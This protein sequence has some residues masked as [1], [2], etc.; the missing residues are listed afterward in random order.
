MNIDSER[1]N[2]V[3]TG[4]KEELSKLRTARPSTTLIEDL[5]VEC[6]GKKMPLKSM[7]LIS[8]K[9]REIIV[10]PWDQSYIEAIEKAIYGSELDL[11]P[12]LDGE[13]IRIP[14]PS[15]SKDRRDQYVRILTGKAEEAKKRVRDLR[16]RTKKKIETSFSKGELGEDDKFRSLD[17]LQELV[18][19]VNDKIES[20]RAKK[21]DQIVNS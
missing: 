19:E 9:D 14:F 4:F 13:L 12:V 6:Y 15:L 8:L 10:K 17:E 20:L 18:D 7:G 3:V 5:E 1:F 16:N 2:G 21:E 11:S